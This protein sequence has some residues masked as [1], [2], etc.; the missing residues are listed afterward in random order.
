MSLLIT[1]PKQNVE[2]EKQFNKRKVQE[3]KKCILQGISRTNQGGSN[4][5]KNII[6]DAVRG[7]GAVAMLLVTAG[8]IDGQGVTLDTKGNA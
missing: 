2:I 5:F 8:F 4:S 3:N 7:R 6:I 1:F